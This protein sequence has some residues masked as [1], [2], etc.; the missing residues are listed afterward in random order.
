MKNYSVFPIPSLCNP[1]SVSSTRKNSILSG[2][3]D[4]LIGKKSMSW[5][6]K[7]PT[8]FINMQTMPQ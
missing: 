8:A 6:Y 2:Y 1:K 5:L 4:S 3:R 7:S